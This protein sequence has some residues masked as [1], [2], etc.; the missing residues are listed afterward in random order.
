M[1]SASM[2]NSQ[3]WSVVCGGQVRHRR[4]FATV[5]SADR[6]GDDAHRWHVEDE[7]AVFRDG[8]VMVPW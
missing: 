3:S 7:L 4:V 5:I 2:V 6:D 1:T 8:H